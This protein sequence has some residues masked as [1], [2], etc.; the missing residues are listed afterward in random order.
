[1][2]EEVRDRNEAGERRPSSDP[3]K[4]IMVIAVVAILAALILDNT[5][6]ARAEERS[7][8]ASSFNDVA[9]LSGVDRTNSSD[10][11]RRGEAKAI[12]GGIEIDLRDAKMEGSE[13]VLEVSAVMGGVKLRVPHDWT[14]VSHVNTVLGG[15]EDKTRHPKEETYRLILEGD[16]VMGGLEIQN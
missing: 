13:A 3:W 5:S 14:V 9:F 7:S 15:F 6:S 2:A 16:V 11:F 4:P 10:R 12:M 1:M 8:P